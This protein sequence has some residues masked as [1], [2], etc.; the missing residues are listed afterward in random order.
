MRKVKKFRIKEF[1][2][3]TLIAIGVFIL[4]LIVYT[5]IRPYFPEKTKTTTRGTRDRPKSKS[6]PEPLLRQSKQILKIRKYLE[7]TETQLIEGFA[8]VNLSSHSGRRHS[9]AGPAQAWWEYSNRKEQKVAWRSAT[10]PEK[11]ATTVVF[12]G[13]TGLMVGE[14]NLLVNDNAVLNFNTGPGL[15][16]EEWQS[17][18]FRLKFFALQINS[19]QERFG[20]F[21]LTIPEEEIFAGKFLK[22]KVTNSAESG[23]L[24]SYFMLSGISNT[25]SKLK[26]K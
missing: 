16:I 4:G 20:V 24:Q 17:G 7:K 10:C 26:A 8:G 13:V 15:E 22:L 2:G 14:A 23:P 9:W 25:L 19:N 11:K 5:S 3:F 12:S 6:K 18:D 21:C 1:L